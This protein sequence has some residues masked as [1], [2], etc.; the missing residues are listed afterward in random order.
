MLFRNH[1][2]DLKS[3]VPKIN[4]NVKQ[5]FHGI[6]E[7]QILIL[8]SLKIDFL[9]AQIFCQR[10]HTC[11][12]NLKRTLQMYNLPPLIGLKT[13]EKYACCN[14]LQYNSLYRCYCCCVYALLFIVVFRQKR[15]KEIYQKRLRVKLHYNNIQVFSSSVSNVLTS[16]YLQGQV[17]QKIK[18]KKQVLANNS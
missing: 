18:Y 9:K 2:F 3:D 13:Y 4:T 5:L 8:R 14:P 15:V 7:K 17:T 16:K 11:V 12:K 6:F 1:F 10:V